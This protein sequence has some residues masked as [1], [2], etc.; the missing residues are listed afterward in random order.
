MIR[1]ASGRA[2]ILFCL[3]TSGALAAIAADGVRTLDDLP[4]GAGRDALVRGCLT[5]HDVGVVLAQGRT[6]S[7]WADAIAVMVDRGAVISEEDR[8]VLLKYL[9]EIAPPH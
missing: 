5:C 8:E 4:S 6:R 1:N 7:E 9:T 3:L 2:T